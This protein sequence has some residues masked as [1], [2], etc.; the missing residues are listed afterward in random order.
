MASDGPSPHLV[1][2]W[3]NNSVGR[4]R[5]PQGIRLV[6]F[7]SLESSS[8]LDWC[9]LVRTRRQ[10]QTSLRLLMC[11]LSWCESVKPSH[12]ANVADRMRV[13]E[14]Q[15]RLGERLTSRWRDWVHGSNPHFMRATKASLSAVPSPTMP[16]PRFCL[17]PPCPRPNHLL[18]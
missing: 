12:A 15:T 9:V 13:G 6:T 5:R 18:T 3:W 17:Q 8:D 4:M 11:W 10:K 2:H 7:Q 1:L 14:R 16:A